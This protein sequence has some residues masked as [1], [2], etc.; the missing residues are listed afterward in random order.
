MATEKL[1]DHGR[2]RIKKEDWEEFGYLCDK[3]GTT[4][5]TVLNKFV[6]RHIRDMRARLKNKEEAAKRR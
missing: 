1:G 5:S 3:L 2:F 4:R 6:Q